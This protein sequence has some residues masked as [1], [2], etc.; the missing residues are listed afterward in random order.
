MSKGMGFVDKRSKR[1]RI[2][3]QEQFERDVSRP[4]YKPNP[5]DGCPMLAEFRLHGLK[6][7]GEAPFLYFLMRWK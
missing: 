4:Y 3:M 7:W 6:R 2:A 1:V 5:L